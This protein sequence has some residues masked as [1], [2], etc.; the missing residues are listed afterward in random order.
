MTTGGSPKRSTR[1]RGHKFGDGLVA[2]STMKKVFI[3]Y[4]DE[5]K[6]WVCNWLLPRIE[7]PFF[8]SF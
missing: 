2:E 4:S 5:D 7:N 8:P 3:S 6:D 1:L